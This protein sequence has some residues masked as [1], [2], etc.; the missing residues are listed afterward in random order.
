MEKITD[1]ALALGS[2]AR[3][4]R[5]FTTD[6]LGEWLTQPAREWSQ[7]RESEQRVRTWATLQEQ[8]QHQDRL[9][10]QEQVRHDRLV[11]EMSE[12]DPI[13]WQARLISGLDCPFCVGT[14]VSLVV[15]GSYA[16]TRRSPQARLAWRVVAGALA[17]N[18]LTAHVNSR[19]D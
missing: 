4:T 13:S 15:I 1:L 11:E 7:V 16:L 3:L 6:T 2:A 8:L 9:T 12:D 17:T 10:L 18:Y 5:F 19:L 14:W